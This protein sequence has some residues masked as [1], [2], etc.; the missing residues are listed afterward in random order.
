MS[1]R[2]RRELG[3]GAMALALLCLVYFVFGALHC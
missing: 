3:G 2:P 1:S